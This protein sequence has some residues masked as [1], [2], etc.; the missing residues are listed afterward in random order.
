MAEIRNWGSNPCFVCLNGDK[1]AFLADP[2]GA[3]EAHAPPNLARGC[4]IILGFFQPH[5]KRKL[6]FASG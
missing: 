1:C 3:E 4:A 2:L 6:N 5:L